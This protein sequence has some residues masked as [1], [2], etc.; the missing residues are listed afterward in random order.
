MSHV[1]R[2]WG[3]TA[4]DSWKDTV[5]CE[6]GRVSIF[7]PQIAVVSEAVLFLF[8]PVSFPS[9][10]LLSPQLLEE[11]PVRCFTPV[12]TDSLLTLQHWISYA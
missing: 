3:K 11:Q 5:P 2:S 8:P 7:D 1:N 4:V 12:S 6:V 10:S 9:P